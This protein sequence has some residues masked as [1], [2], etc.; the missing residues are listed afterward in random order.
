MNLFS[1]LAERVKIGSSAK[2]KSLT[3]GLRGL[4]LLGM[5]YFIPCQEASALSSWEDFNALDEITWIPEK[6][7]IHY[8]IRAAQ[9]WGGLATGGCAWGVETGEKLTLTQNTSTKRTINIMMNEDYQPNGSN[10]DGKALEYKLITED[11]PITEESGKTYFLDFYIP[12]ETADIEKTITIDLEGY[13]WR[14]G[15]AKDE[16]IS[17]KA[18]RKVHLSYPKN[19]KYKITKVYYDCGLDTEGNL[20]A[21]RISFDWTRDNNS[22]I[23][24]YGNVFLCE[25]DASTGTDL[26]GI[27]SH[28]AKNSP[29][30]FAVYTFDTDTP[31][32][33]LSKSKTYKIRQEFILEPVAN[34][35][36]GEINYMFESAPVVVNAYPQATDFT[37]NLNND[38]DAMLINWEIPEAPSSD[39][40]DG[41][42]LLTNIRSVGEKVVSEDTIIVQ[43]EG[44]KTEYSCE[45]PIAS[46][47]STYKISLE[48]ASSKDVECF[49]YYKI[50]KGLK[51]TAYHA[52]P[53]QPRAVL[54]DDQSSVILSWE[55]TGSVWSEGTEFY[56]QKSWKI[57]GGDTIVTTQLTKEEFKKKS[58]TDKSDECNTYTYA[59][60]MWPGDG[61]GNKKVPVDGEFTTVCKPDSVYL[62]IQDGANGK[63][64]LFVGTCNTYK[65]RFVPEKDWAIESVSFN[66]KDVTNE[67]VSNTYQTPEILEN[68]TLSVVYRKSIL[69]NAPK[70]SNNALRLWV[71]NGSIVISNAR[72][73][74]NITVTNMLGNVVYSD[75]ADASEMTIELPNSGV[76][77]VIVDGETFKVAL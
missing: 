11:S 36:K 29:E 14:R 37:C 35:I 20:V 49:S 48:R 24:E 52:Y 41:A 38:K 65:F 51:L 7:V 26:L 74:A 16:E 46:G 2:R 76:F 31:H 55:I 64:D 50:T 30:P 3:R 47:E 34:N 12:V 39:Y 44:G 27:T 54:S 63:M 15:A 77:I 23:T 75:E 71:D 28:P 67:L 68:S 72:I 45:M 40:D 59:L 13:W 6:G 53:S 17:I 19:P 66:G 62:T 60:I 56:L 70:R 61:T 21:P 5:L 22:D 18:Y 1:Y 8:K 58:Y 57:P 10:V 4:T 32:H 69:T 9:T 25:G 73:G 43:Y 42:F 33:D